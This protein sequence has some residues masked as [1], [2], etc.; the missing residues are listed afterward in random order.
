MFG[1][2]LIA[3]FLF[4]S[5]N[6]P[7]LATLE[8]TVTHAASKTP[9]RKVKVSLTSIGSEGGESVETT[10]DGKFVLKDVKPGRYRISATK[11]GYETTAFGGRQP[12]EA[13]GQVVR[14]DPGVGAGHLDIALPKH[15]VIA[16]KILDADSEPVPRALV[17]ALGNVYQRGRRI[18]IPR[19][20]VPVISNDLGEY[21]IGE[22][23][24]GKYILCAIPAGLYQPVPDAKK[25]K[26]GS[27]ESIITTCFPNVPQMGDA[28]MLEIK[29]S[30]EVTGIDIRLLKT[31]TVT[32]QGRITGAPAGGGAVS[33]LN[34]NTKNSGPMGNAI[35]PRAFVMSADGAF[36]FKNVP[37]GSYILHTLAT[38][39]GN[40]P[41]VVKASV[42]IGDQPV[43]DLQVPAVTP[44]EIKAKVIAEPGPEL[45]ITS[46]RVIL[47]PAD[48]ITHAL[49]MGTPNADG[50]LTLTNLVPGRHRVN[51]TGVPSTHYVREIRAG[52][53]AADGDEVEITSP[54]TPLTLSFA[55]GNAEIT[56]V[57]RT[58][59]GEPAPGAYVGLIPEPRRAFRFRLTRGDQNGM[60]KLGN[61]P[62]GEYRLV[63]LDKI[64][65]GSLEDEEF[66]KPLLSKMK[67]VKVEERGTQSQDLIVHSG[68]A[69]R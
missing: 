4:Q 1:P 7:K 14:V 44:F 8:G 56:G 25:S 12:G 22:L 23:P 34:L 53:Q 42:D 46:I 24:P 51:L 52:D 29:D 36:E 18:R 17:M 66:L 16:G 9:I 11:A 27:E 65:A 43:T 37:P 63:A 50:D 31:R 6:E 45:K 19:G 13:L 59:K 41:F 30:S 20:T 67:K 40:A 33:I 54:A 58:E 49:A 35:H 15:G 64:E 10:D 2:I 47:M 61:L 5:P 57:A 21:R 69:E 39:L 55:V 38:G 48:E 62:P 3:L 28:T 26:P 32:V 68:A 60:F